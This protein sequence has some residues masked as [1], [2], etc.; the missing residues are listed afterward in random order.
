MGY[1]IYQFRE[2]LKNKARLAI[3]FSI[4]WMYIVLLIISGIA[5]ISDGT[6][7]N[8]AMV[9]I[10]LLFTI[11]TSFFPSFISSK[12]E[13]KDTTKKDIKTT[14]IF[15]LLLIIILIFPILLV[16]GFILLLLPFFLLFFLPF[17][18]FKIYGLFVVPIIF[19]AITTLPIT[20]YAYKK[21][22]GLVDKLLGARYINM[23]DQKEYLVYQVFDNIRIAFG[24]NNVELRVIPWNIINAMVV[25]SKDKSVVYIT[26]GAIEKLEYYELESVFAHEFIHIKNR[27]SYYITLINIV[28]LATAIII[29]TFILALSKNRDRRSGSGV[30]LLL[31]LFILLAFLNKIIMDKIQE[32][33]SKYRETL[34]DIGSALTTKYPDGLVS[35]LVKIAYMDKENYRNINIPEN[36][37]ALLFSYEGE[38]HPKIWERLLYLHRYARASLPDQFEDIKMKNL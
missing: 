16:E 17:S 28:A 10:A 38:T 27:D 7:G 12:D 6:G 26:E 3:I 1:N 35:T 21:P 34:A 14:I 18:Y 11:Y 32:K 4:L 24:M 9:F 29:T 33:F 22:D 2:E 37:K 25:S 13:K 5:Y 36:I 30:S 23:R 20:Y 19:I 8:V 31:L 15:L